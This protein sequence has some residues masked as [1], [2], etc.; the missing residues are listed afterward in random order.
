MMRLAREI[1]LRRFD[2]EK[3]YRFVARCS[4]SYNNSFS[5][6]LCGFASP[7]A[8]ENEYRELATGIK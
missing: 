1:S 5:A 8:F 2:G 3:N 7:G 4:F 6:P